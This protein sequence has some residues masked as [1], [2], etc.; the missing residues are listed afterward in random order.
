MALNRLLEESGSDPLFEK[1]CAPYC[2]ETMGR[3]GVPPGVLFRMV[4]VGLFEGLKSHQSISWRCT[5]S[6]SLSDFLD[7]GPTDSAPNHACVS[8]T[9]KRIPE[10][11]FNEDFCFILSVAAHK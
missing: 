7:L 2:A 11:A 5:D 8:K 4:F 9:H 1:L 6:R 3:S 10:V